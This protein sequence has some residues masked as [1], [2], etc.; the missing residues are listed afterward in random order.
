MENV[1]KQKTPADKMLN[2]VIVLVILAFLAAG[3]YAV[4]GVVSKNIEENAIMSGKK[5]P[6]V[7]YLANLQSKTVDEYLAQYNLTAGDT[8]TAKSPESEMVNQM[9]LEF[10]MSYVGETQ[11]ADELIAQDNMSDIATKDM[12]H[13]EYIDLKNAQPLSKIYGDAE[14]VNQINEQL[15]NAGIEANLTPEMTYGEFEQILMDNGAQLQAAAQEQAQQETP[16][17]A[18]PAAE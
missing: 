11:T 12:T 10:Y 13:S 2:T 6:T 9:S 7:E 8:I 16:S 1:K 18:A 5:E 4:W 17:E 3:V 14:A 15:K